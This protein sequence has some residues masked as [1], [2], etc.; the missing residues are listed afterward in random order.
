MAN[1]YITKCEGVV[2]DALKGELGGDKLYFH[3]GFYNYLF[4]KSEEKNDEA[5]TTKFDQV[6][7]DVKALLA[8]NP[9]KGNSMVHSSLHSAGLNKNI[10]CSPYLLLNAI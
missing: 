8:K 5:S 2:P 10:L 7:T 4:D 6:T 9:G 1:I 3:S